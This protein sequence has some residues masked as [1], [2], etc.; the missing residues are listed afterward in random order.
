MRVES[1][2]RHL[3]SSFTQAKHFAR[4][5]DGAVAYFSLSLFLIMFLIGGMAVDLMRF[6]HTR[7]TLQQ[8]MDRSVLAGAS[9]QQTLPP[10]SVVTDYFAKAGLA[11]FLDAS[12]IVVTQTLNSRNVKAKASAISYNIFMDMLGVDQ[13]VAPA[14]AAAEQRRTNVEIVLVLD[15]S[16]SMGDPSGTTT[17]I[18]ALKTA[19][20]S[21]VDTVLA[22]DT[23]N[24]ISIAIVPYNA[25]VNMSAQLRSKYNATYNHGVADINC[26]E[27]P[28]STYAQLDLSRSL[29]MPMYSHA[30]N[31]SST[32]RNTSFQAVTSNG[33]GAQQ[34]DPQ[35][36]AHIMLPSNNKIALKAKIDGLIAEGNTS[37]MLGMR[38]GVA[39]LDPGARPLFNELIGLGSIS[40]N[41][42]GRPF[43]YT[44]PDKMKVIVLMTDGEHV[45]HNIVKDAFKGGPAPIPLSPIWRSSGDG[46]FSIQHATGRPTGI[47][48]QFWVP[49]LCV[50]TTCKDGVNTAEA[51]KATAWNSGSGTAQ[52]SWQQVWSK[53]RVQ[54]VAWQL[55]ARALGTSSANRDTVY[56]NTL[57][58]MVTT[59]ASASSMNSM[60]SQS[61]TLAKAQGVSVYGIAF[62]AP[63]N[64][65]TQ[66]TNCSSSPK[67]NYYFNATGLNISAVF[68]TIAS[69]ISQLRLT[70]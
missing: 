35:P 19:A 17:K 25:Q 20:K 8:T 65:Q 4:R 30:D 67:S 24:R 28:A 33:I 23:E 40:S 6:E 59:F 43:D 42:T 36:A 66:I 1:L 50:S 52:Q 9:L 45:A 51:W 21:F 15:I 53:V 39:L 37:I 68:Q 41:F 58:N 11:E 31:T 5:E 27:V 70:Q 47:T 3:M 57:S 60:L 12:S 55:Y 7:V 32:T 69:N 34:C 61:C 26:L 16:G 13:L 54:W 2:F 48:N 64:G 10:A 22:N 56:N 49:H 38:W 62:E 18:A 29:P 14:S 63:T 44:D 46:N